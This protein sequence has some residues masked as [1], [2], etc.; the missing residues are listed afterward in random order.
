M[1][2]SGIRGKTRDAMFAA[3]KD[4]CAELLESKGLWLRA[5]AQWGKLVDK[6]RDDELRDFYVFRREYCINE[7]NEQHRLRINLYNE[8]M[9]LG[10]VRKHIDE[11][12]RKTNLGP[13]SS[14]SI[15]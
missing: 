6:C 8:R 2:S 1:A 7:S 10:P 14:F 15:D 11:V 5:A 13:V 12:Y 9:D 4:E 3:S